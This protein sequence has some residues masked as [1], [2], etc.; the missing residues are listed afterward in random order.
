MWVGTSVISPEGDV[1]PAGFYK[2][3]ET[4]ERVVAALG[5]R[6]VGCASDRLAARGYIK[7]TADGCIFLA[8]YGP[9]ERI[10][11][12]QFDAIFDMVTALSE[13][14]EPDN[15]RI[16]ADGLLERLDRLEVR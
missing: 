14:R 16:T 1:H 7:I 15:G 12:A 8:D 4:C 9:A 13:G 5:I 2:H 6:G 3:E 10:T 11:Q